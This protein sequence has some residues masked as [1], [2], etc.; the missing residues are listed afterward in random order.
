[1]FTLLRGAHG[2]RSLIP[3]KMARFPVL[4]LTRGNYKQVSTILTE[5]AMDRTA[6]T[7]EARDKLMNNLKAVIKDAEELLK[8]TGQQV[9]DGYQSARAKFETSLKSAKNGLSNAEESLIA[10]TKDAAQSTDK[11][12]QDHPWQSVGV[13]AIAGLVIGLLIGRR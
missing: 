9:D 10:R 4:T 7:S 6:Q 3:R 11:Y 1:M 2:K 8:N 12:V 5:R 13:G